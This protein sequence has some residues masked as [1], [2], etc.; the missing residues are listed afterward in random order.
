M[1]E[2][3]LEITLDDTL[4]KEQDVDALMAFYKEMNFNSFQSDLLNSGATTVEEAPKA[5]RPNVKR[6]SEITEDMLKCATSVHFET[7]E[8]NYHVADV[9]AVAFGNEKEVFVT[10]LNTAVA[11]EA[12]KKWLADASIEKHLFDTK[13]AKVLAHR[14]GLVLAGAQI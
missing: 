13:A 11:S 4:R 5:Q 8:A 1:W 10:D 6:V 2:S 3:P 9:I 12:F 14:F 7:L